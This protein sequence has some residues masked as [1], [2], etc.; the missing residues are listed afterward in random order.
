MIPIFVKLPSLKDPIYH[1]IE[2]TLLSDDYKFDKLQLN[3]FTNIAKKLNLV[4]IMDSYDELRNELIGTNLAQTNRIF[5][6]FP[7]CK[8][9][10]TSRSET[11]QSSQNYHL[12]FKRKD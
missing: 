5:E 3:E 2:E 1:A 6:K 7:Y 11:L 9:I 8:I 10:F 12:W 4:L